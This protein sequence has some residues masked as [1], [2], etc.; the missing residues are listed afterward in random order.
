[1]II[2]KPHLKLEMYRY[3]LVLGSSAQLTPIP[4]ITFESIEI[5]LFGLARACMGL[6]WVGGVGGW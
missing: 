6:G 2:V 3:T 1:M 4:Y 5:G